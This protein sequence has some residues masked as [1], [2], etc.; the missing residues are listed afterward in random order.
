MQVSWIDE[1]SLRDLVGKLTEEGGALDAKAKASPSWEIHTLP[2][3][4]VDER[5]EADD[6]ME[7][8]QPEAEPLP[9]EPS[10]P[11]ADAVADVS[12]VMIDQIRDRLRSVRERALDAGLLKPAEPVAGLP[13]ACATPVGTGGTAEAGGTPGVARPHAVEFEIP[14]GPVPARLDAYAGWAGQ[15]LGD[16]ELFL[17]DEEG[18]LLW[19]VQAKSGLVLSAMLAWSAARNTSA[20]SATEMPSVLR[21]PQASG[22]SISI[23]PCR[24]RHGMIQVGIRR[25]EAVS[26]ED[27]DCLREALI[28][29]IDV[30]EA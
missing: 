21:H 28:A 5:L 12:A 2:D 20:S 13:E 6:L 8:A 10:P 24:T 27:A 14:V 19:G 7:S 4:V 15:W 26:D 22:G 16:A 29:A 18:H 1:G 25:E 3:P 23:I 9:E 17:L 30:G 11:L